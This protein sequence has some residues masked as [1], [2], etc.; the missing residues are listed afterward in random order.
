MDLALVEEEGGVA[1]GTVVTESAVKL[2]EMGVLAVLMAQQGLLVAALVAAVAAG[3][4]WG[5]CA[6][7]VLGS[8]VLLKLILPL[9]RK[10]THLT[11]EGLSLVAQFVAAQLI[12]PM[13]AVRAL[14]ALVSEVPCMFPHV[15]TQ[16]VLPLGDIATFRTH[17]ILGIRVGQHMLGEVAHIPAR[18]VTQLTLVRF[19][20][21]MQQH[22][23]DKH[24]L[25]GS[26][27]VALRAL[28]DLLMS[29]HLANVVLV[30]YWV[31]GGK[32]AEGAP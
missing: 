26:G 14:V 16:V 28:V 21:S 7:V 9:A 17:V 23:S 15:H 11:H 18:E 19:L 31:E 27:K 1:E 20:S 32:G 5:G 29:V 12:G 2:P 10:G 3:V 24:P 6:R 13:A 30:G 22:V 8:H 25:V 4:E